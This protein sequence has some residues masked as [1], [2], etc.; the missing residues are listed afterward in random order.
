MPRLLLCIICFLFI[1]TTSSAQQ[2][3]Q[4]IRG[5]VYDKDANYPLI[6]VNVAIMLN[7]KIL[8][9]GVSDNEGNFRIENIDIGR[10]NLNATYIGYLYCPIKKLGEAEAAPFYSLEVTTP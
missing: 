6:G 2:L 8:A 1:N 9:S 7:E 5:T 10:V 4:S 3:K